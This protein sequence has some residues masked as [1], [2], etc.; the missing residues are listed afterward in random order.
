MSRLR[1]LLA[2]NSPLSRKIIHACLK[3]MSVEMIHDCFDGD[4][5]LEFLEQGVGFNVLFLDTNITGIDYKTI[6]LRMK[7]HYWLQS[8]TVFILSSQI[9]KAE[10]EF[11][12][13]NGVSLFIERP[14]NVAKLESIVIPVLRKISYSENSDFFFIQEYREEILQILKNKNI[15][16]D[17]QES[18]DL[19]IMKNDHTILKIKLSLVLK[20]IILE[21]II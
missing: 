1:V 19:L 5:V 10:Y 18:E 15:T 20:N 4:C 8:I 6:I 16:I 2:D 13:R 7:E 12:K 9:P 17:I 21:H 3:K 11:L 14:F